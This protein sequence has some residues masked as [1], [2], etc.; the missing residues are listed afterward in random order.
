MRTIQFQISD[1]LEK[2]IS[3]YTMNIQGFINNAIN[4]Y[5]KKSQNKLIEKRLIEGY[6]YSS[7]ESLDINKE[8]EKIEIN[9]C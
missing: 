5:I 2:K 9:N 4:D 3:L 8:F 7:K 1:E 6:Q